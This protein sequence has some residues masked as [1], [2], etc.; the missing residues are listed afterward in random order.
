MRWSHSLAVEIETRNAKLL[1][2]AMADE[3]RQ[4]SQAA[5][6]ADEPFDGSATLKKQ[7]LDDAA[8]EQRQKP[9]VIRP[10]PTL[11][12]VDLENAK[13]VTE[14]FREYDQ[15]IRG[16]GV[17]DDD[18]PDNV[19]DEHAMLRLQK[20]KHD[21]VFIAQV[22]Q[23]QEHGFDVRKVE[24]LKPETRDVFYDAIACS[25]I[26]MAKKDAEI[27]QLKDENRK[28]QEQ[29]EASAARPMSYTHKSTSRHYQ[30]PTAPSQ[31]PEP[32]HQRYDRRE[33]VSNSVFEKLK[34][35]KPPSRFDKGQ[36][37]EF[38]DKYSAVLSGVRPLI[39]GKVS[40]KCS[41]SS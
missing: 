19:L 21:E 18:I 12:N 1:A 14:K 30:P 38:I 8:G 13:L 10:A 5:Q 16:S 24:A 36:D 3:Q 29:K 4:Q 33:P 31:A 25:N 6:Q 15:W 40:Q 27:E 17:E 7:R 32:Q 35:L 20:K 11:E 2:R 26:S 34:D 41:G 9:R 28:L 37:P 39:Q 22:R 23:M